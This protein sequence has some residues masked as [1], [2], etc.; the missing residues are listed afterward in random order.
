M[1]AARYLTAILIAS[2]VTFGLFFLMQALVV[3]DEVRLSD[4]ENIRILDVVRVDREQKPKREET[5]VQKPD[6]PD[7]PPPDLNIPNASTNLS[8]QALNFGQLSM[9]ADLSASGPALGAP[10]DGDYLPLVRIQPQ[11][12]RRA[13]ER[14]VEGYVIVELTVTPDGTT[15]D[16]QVVE[17]EPSGYF[18][19]AAKRAAEK[20]KY[21]PKVVNGEPIM[22]N[23][24]RYLFTFELEDGRR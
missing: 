1:M 11:Y 21:K 17:A 5:E 2:G 8:G 10:T 7:A 18:E 24:V 16:I 23:G 13:A 4:V 12:P 22:V 3:T 19:R 15:R 6:K 20:F 9:G 14:G